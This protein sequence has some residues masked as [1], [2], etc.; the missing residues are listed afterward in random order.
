MSGNKTRPTGR[1]VIEFLD[2]VPSETRKEDAFRLMDMMQEITGDP[3]TM[4]GPSIIGFGECHYVYSSGREGD[5]PLAS[6]APR[7]SNLV[8]YLDPGFEGYSDLLEKLGK[9]KTGAVCLYINKLADVDEAVLRK[10][11]KL[12][13][14]Y[15]K[16]E[17]DIE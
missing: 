7:S 4:W 14:E 12:S 13:Y 8:I 2:E 3:P 6:F 15:T 16:T 10:M 1:N 5:M 9:H 17:W 11:I